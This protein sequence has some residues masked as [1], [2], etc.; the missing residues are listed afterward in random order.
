M[1]INHQMIPENRCLCRKN[2]RRKPDARLLNKWICYQ[3]PIVA[4]RNPKLLLTP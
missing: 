4:N 1:S 3:H 2:F